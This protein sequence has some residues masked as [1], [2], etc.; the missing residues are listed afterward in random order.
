MT[1]YTEDDVRA[2]YAKLRELMK[3]AKAPKG[4]EK[5]HAIEEQVAIV[6]A[7]IKQKDEDEFQLDGLERRADIALEGAHVELFEKICGWA[8]LKRAKKHTDLGVWNNT[9]FQMHNVIQYRSGHSVKLATRLAKSKQ[10]FKSLKSILKWYFGKEMHI[11]PIIRN[12]IIL[13]ETAPVAI[14]P[15]RSL[16]NLLFDI[17]SN[18]TTSETNTSK[19]KVKVA[20]IMYACTY[21]L[22][23]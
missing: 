2:A 17:Y 10:Y 3:K 22:S 4:D 11:I 1:S 7:Q 8:K 21:L 6:H 9:F 13:C 18:K 12:L 14:G 19:E 5:R 23:R 15:A 16:Y 20:N